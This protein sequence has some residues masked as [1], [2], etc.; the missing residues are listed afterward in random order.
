MCAGGFWGTV[1]STDEHPFTDDD[2]EVACYQLGFAGKAVTKSVY[3][4]KLHN[5]CAPEGADIWMRNVTCKGKEEYLSNCKYINNAGTCATEHTDDAMIRC[6][7]EYFYI[8]KDTLVVNV[9][10]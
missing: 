7:G 1:C 8:P 2:A 5:D 4:C 3:R 9:E 6:S 10:K